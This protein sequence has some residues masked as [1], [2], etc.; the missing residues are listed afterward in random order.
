MSNNHDPAFL[1]FA[2]AIGL[3]VLAIV[4]IKLLGGI[5]GAILGIVFTVII[6]LVLGALVFGVVRALKR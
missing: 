4:G 1:N 5:I 6:I 2:K 3:V